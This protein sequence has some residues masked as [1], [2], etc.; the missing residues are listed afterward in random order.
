MAGTDLQHWR[1]VGRLSLAEVSLLIVGADPNSPRSPDAE[2]LA[3]A[4]TVEKAIVQALERARE[5]ASDYLTD[6]RTEKDP[7]L[8]DLFEGHYGEQLL[9]T[10]GLRH[11]VRA[12]LE[13]RNYVRLPGLADTSS[14][15]TINADEFE[16]W[17][18]EK[19]IQSVF[20][21]GS[22]QILDLRTRGPS[23]S[24]G[25]RIDDAADPS[26]S[27]GP[28]PWGTYET[29]YLR[30]LA[31]AAQCWWVNFDPDDNTTAPTNEQVSNWLQARGTVGKSLADKMA[32][33][34]R[35]DGLPTGPRT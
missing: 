16:W 18:D 6:P 2:T 27:A 11:E 24:G 26:S 15:S 33:I 13:S 32:T 23:A 7:L 9:I 14:D 5:A 30:E 1:G 4:K 25:P 10:L 35:A 3:K 20:R 17:L 22:G 31:A 29:K 8:P 34:L 21:F 28:W 19:G 12:A